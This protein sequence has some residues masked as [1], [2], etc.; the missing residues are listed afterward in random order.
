MFMHFYLV[1]IK[2]NKLFQIILTVNT[3]EI[4]HEL[5]HYSA[6]TQHMGLSSHSLKLKTLRDSFSP[7]YSLYNTTPQTSALTIVSASRCESALEKK[8][9]KG[10]L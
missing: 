2:R 7:L 5:L 6:I 10:Y 1:W 4:V 9:V 3:P 8:A